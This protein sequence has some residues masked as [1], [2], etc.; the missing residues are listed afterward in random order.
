MPLPPASGNTPSLLNMTLEHCMRTW[1]L[2]MVT[3]TSFFNSPRC[4]WAM[5]LMATINYLFWFLQV[6]GGESAHVCV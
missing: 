1:H 2:Y 4:R 3:G 5:R 6:G